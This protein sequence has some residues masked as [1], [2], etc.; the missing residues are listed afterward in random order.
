MGQNNTAGIDA[1]NDPEKVLI[2]DIHGVSA[3]IWF[4]IASWERKLQICV[5]I[6]VALP[7]H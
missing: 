1:L 3:D 6:N 5:A 4:A 7:E 2:E